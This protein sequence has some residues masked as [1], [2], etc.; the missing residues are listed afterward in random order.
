MKLKVALRSLIAVLLTLSIFYLIAKD[1]DI[2][3][4]QTDGEPSSLSGELP[5]EYCLRDEYVVLAQNQDA[6]GYCWNF[7]ATMAASTTIMKATGEY[8]DFSELWTGV[9]LYNCTNKHS[10]IGAGGSLSYQHNAM[11][12]SGLMLEADLPYQYSY[13]VSNENAADYYNFYEKY[14]NS[15]LANTIADDINYYSMTKV[16]EIKQHLYNHGSLYLAFSFK[17]GFVDDGG[18]AFYL[19]PNQQSYNSSHAVSLIGWDD[20]YEVEVYLDGSDVPT[21]FKGAWIILNSYTE[22]SGNDGISLV[23]YD[24]KNIS[25][26]C[27]YRYEPDMTGELYFYDKIESGYSYPNNLIGK[28]YGDYTAE[29]G[30]SK[31]KNI[32]YDD[33]NL[34]YSYVI[35]DGAEIKGIDIYL[36]NRNVTSDFAVTWDNVQKR[37]YISKSDAPY[38][39]YK[40]IVTYGN[41]DDTDKYLNNFFVTYGLFGEEIEYDYDK[42]DNTFNLGR[43]LEFYSFITSDKNYVIYTRHLNGEVAFRPTEQSV[44]SDRNMS[45]PTLS[46]EIL[47]G[48]SVTKTHTVTADS[49]YE[50]DYDFT[51]EYCADLTMQPVNVYYDLGGGVNHPENYGRELASPTTDLALYAPTREGYT[52]GGWYLGYSS[53]SKPLVEKDG[54]YYIDWED[55]HHMGES[56]SVH[57]GSHYK[58]YYKNSNTVFVYAHWLEEEYH[59]ISI[60]V[61]GD[62]IVPINKNIL[63]SSKESA[64]YFFKPK[65]GACLARLEINGERVV[66]DEFI[67]AAKYGYLVENP[68]EDISIVATFAQGVLLSFKL[69]ENVKSA[70][71]MAVKDG[72]AVKFYDGDFISSEYF[73]SIL[74]R[75]NQRVFG[76]QSGIALTPSLRYLDDISDRIPPRLDPDDSILQRPD[77]DNLIPNPILPDRDDE[78]DDLLP[79]RT[80]GTTQ[81]VLVVEFEEDNPGY[82]YVPDGVGEYSVVERGV[83]KK[84]ISISKSD[85]FREISIASPT[86]IPTGDSAEVSYS[87]SGYYLDHYISTDKNATSG[88]KNTLS[89]KTGDVAYVFIKANA[90]TVAYRYAPPASFDY[91]GNQWYRRAILVTEDTVELGRIS[92]SRSY[93]RYIVTWKNWDGS[94]IYEESYRYGSTP[95]FYDSE[96]KSDVPTRPDDDTYTYTFAGWDTPINTVSGN[97]TYTATYDSVYRIFN[98]TYETPENG[99]II[100]NGADSL[101]CTESRTYTFIPNDGYR[102]LDVLIDGVSVG[103]LSSYT[104]EDV[105]SDKTLKVTFEK[106]KCTVSVSAGKG[107]TATEGKCVEF[108]ETVRVDF[109]PSF[110]YRIKDVVIDGVSIG[111]ADSYVFTSLSTDHTVSVEYELNREL[112]IA[113]AAALLVLIL[114]AILLTAL[115]RSRRARAPRTRLVIRL[116]RKD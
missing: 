43:E 17:K 110:G 83:Y 26:I 86:E 30:Y 4:A 10:T 96:I 38:G 71:V 54:R 57:A 5:S 37:F 16:D 73:S 55:I 65:S 35:S 112:I 29:S 76:V 68:G 27:G 97:V 33:V 56:P 46:Y 108:G 15:A 25:S 89:C 70:Y 19:P 79:I 77:I 113:A 78:M 101:N 20:N 92:V 36:D 14:S 49:G 115:I 62:G 109:T 58:K 63:L 28:Y 39:N 72:V 51:F 66:G 88:E 9:S 1:G 53:G 59:S 12:L 13:T 40:V 34:E 23:L 18:G 98:I 41:G 82:T 94:I 93:R 45:V 116:R 69:G 22:T 75:P 105:H 24:D 50:L 52:F 2:S 3:Y 64:R 47:D 100:A 102:I 48:V 60:T 84:V 104:F 67:N 11:K 80:Y 95:S 61:N 31:Q 42:N 103:A 6:H 7:A 44:Y 106:I 111:A 87:V 107:G 81:F 32:F 91:I 8:Y 74:L 21:V 85:K 90:E 114:L 99:R